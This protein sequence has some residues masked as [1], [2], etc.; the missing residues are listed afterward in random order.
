MLTLIERLDFLEACG[1]TKF[2]G[3][4]YKQAYKRATG[5]DL[6]WIVEELYM[7]DCIS[8]AVKDLVYCAYMYGAR[9]AK[10][11]KSTDN[12]VKSLNTISYESEGRAIRT[13]LPFRTLTAGMAKLGHYMEK[14]KA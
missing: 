13:V 6:K 8:K 14:E 5:Y 9:V 10:K 3:L 4:N 12:I 1:T 11:Y 2:I 7:R